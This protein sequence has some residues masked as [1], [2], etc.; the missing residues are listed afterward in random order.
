MTQLQ[1]PFSAQADLP[2][3]AFSAMRQ[4]LLS[5]VKAENFK[6]IEDADRTLRVQT[7][8]RIIG[9]RPG[10]RTEVAGIVVAAGERRLF[11]D[12]SRFRFGLFRA[13]FAMK[14]IRNGNQIYRRVSA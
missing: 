4:M 12:L 11:V 14:E 3:I 9:L 5:Q 8:L 2:G 1:L 13:M 10:H 7:S 6:V